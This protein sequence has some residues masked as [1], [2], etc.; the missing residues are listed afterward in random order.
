MK[1]KTRKSMTYKLLI[2]H[3]LPLYQ[4]YLKGNQFTHYVNVSSH[5]FLWIKYES[6]CVYIYPQLFLLY[7]WVLT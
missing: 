3:F 2:L 7:K 6:L 4:N 1:P 5:M